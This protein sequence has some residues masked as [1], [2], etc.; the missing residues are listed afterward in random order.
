MRAT[1][2]VV[3]VVL[4]ILLVGCSNSTSDGTK[5]GGVFFGGTEGIVASFDPLGVVEDGVS[6]I[7]DTEGFSLDVLLKNKGEEVVPPG[8]VS[9]RLLGPAPA[10]FTGI[11]AWT[12]ASR[13]EIDKVSEFNPQGGEEVVSFAANSTARYTKAVTG[14]IDLAW[15]VEYTY[16]YKTYGIIDN[17]CFKGDPTDEKV[18]KVEEKKT[19]AVSGAPITITN[20]E[21]DAAGKGIMVLKIDV[22]N[23]GQGRAAV[24]GEEFDNRFSQIGYSIDESQ[25]WQCKSGGLEN[26][27]RLVDNKA[28]IICK[29][30]T[31]LADQDLYTK[32]IAFTLQYKYRDVAQEKLRVKE[33][34]R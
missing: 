5:K 30:K 25:L 27:A 19:V 28:Q 18:C 32:S 10:D 2:I 3:M 14:F 34:A 31:A 20:V 24:V 8:K 13:G 21:E 23:K 9:L 17:V 7:Y 12:L 29:L 16:D 6:S 4:G 26:K 11:P 33:S 22:E 1:P 15:N